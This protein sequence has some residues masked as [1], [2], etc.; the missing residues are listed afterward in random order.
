MQ[1]LI[2]MIGQSIPAILLLTN[3]AFAAD[4]LPSAIPSKESFLNLTEI[5]KS[6]PIIYSLLILMSIIALTI[7]LYSMIT[8]RLSEM[9]PKDLL[10]KVR[11]LFLERRYEAALTTCQK[12]KSVTSDILAAGL[13]VR[14]H[15][16]QIMIESMKSEGRRSGNSL[17]QRV[18]LLNEISVVAPMLGLLGTVVGLFFAFYE[19]SRTP[20]SI[21][22][23]FDGLGIAVGTTVVGLVVSILSMIFYT[24]LKFR[25]ISLMNTIENESLSLVSLVETENTAPTNLSNRG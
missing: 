4:I 14:R 1:H 5:F 21:A 10:I 12:E 3:D 22:S 15:G 18:S 9:M 8:L 7:W 19:N 2:N 11:E 16:P 23:I 24:T 20:D 6:C 17:W 13:S 25:V